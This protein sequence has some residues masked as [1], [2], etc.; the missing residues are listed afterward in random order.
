[1]RRICCI[2]FL[3]CAAFA[4][5]TG[6]KP[7]PDDYPVQALAKVLGQP[8]ALGAEFMVHS[9]SRG[10]ES[11][12]APEFLV[13]EV[14]LYPAKDANLTVSPS[15]FTLRINGKKQVL[16]PQPPGLVASSLSHPEWQNR[17]R[18]E[19]GGGMGGIGI[20]TPRPRPTNM[21]GQQPDGTQDN[22]SGTE[23]RP[24]VSPQQ[25]AVET[26]LPSGEFHKPVSGYLYFSFKGKT[27]SIKSL[28]LLYEETVVK[29]R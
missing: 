24:R 25:L 8:V 12:I 21:P 2:F 4:Q 14:A 3:A 10:E 16:P 26:A 27:S 17:P 5:G 18:F 29:L 9:F 6:P 23:P 28:D 1:M 22:P 19:A 11:Y 13:V 15:Q 20:G 7:K